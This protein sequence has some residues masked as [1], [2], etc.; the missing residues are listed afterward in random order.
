[1]TR[2][3]RVVFLLVG[4]GSAVAAALLARRGG[5][6]V[7]VRIGVPAGGRIEKTDAEW[8]AE[9]S[10]QSFRVTRQAGTERAYAGATWD[11]HAD[12]EYR[13]V[14]RGQPLFD[15]AAKFDSG[16]GWPSFWQP[17]DENAVSPF[18]DRDPLGAR[19]EVTCGR[20]DAHLGHVFGDG[21]GPPA[22]GTA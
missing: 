6:R 15:S 2:G 3:I 11:A 16:T 8:R 20:C 7:P 17:A 18:E 19:T 9:L 12:G 13:C 1:M 5:E 14:C 22:C 4:V 10:E 21:P